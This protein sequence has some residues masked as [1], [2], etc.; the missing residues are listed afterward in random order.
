MLFFTFLLFISTSG[1][2]VLEEECLNYTIYP[3]QYQL[4]I[5]PH[6]FKDGTTYFDCDLLI[7]VIANAPNINV[8]ELDAK[9]LEIKVGSIKV[10]DGGMDIVNEH[11]PYELD[12]KKGKLFIYLKEPLKQFSASK[13]QYI[14][15]LLF[16]KY[17]S[18]ESEGVFTVPYKGDDGKQT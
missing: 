1:A 5:I 14:I 8:I 13:T 2:Y 3:A 10:L 18:P 11:R 12:N 4:T 9:D 17:V 16:V 6:I 7:T 15:R